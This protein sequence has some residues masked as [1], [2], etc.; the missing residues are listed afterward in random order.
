R[1]SQ[2]YFRGNLTPTGAAP[3][4]YEYDSVGGTLLSGAFAMA[5]GAHDMPLSTPAEATPFHLVGYTWGSG[6]LEL[7][8]RPWPAGD[9]GARSAPSADD[10]GETLRWA[11]ARGPS[12]T[13]RRAGRRCRA[14]AAGSAT[15]PPEGGRHGPAPPGRPF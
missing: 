5:P 15:A 1:S 13:W 10:T 3:Q 7:L 4:V 6:R 11:I 12:W 2:M 9:A 14:S 8:W